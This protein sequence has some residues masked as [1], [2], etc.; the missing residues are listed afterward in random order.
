MKKIKITESQYRRIITEGEGVSVNPEILKNKSVIVLEMGK[1]LEKTFREL[2]ND[3]IVAMDDQE[4][5]DMIS[6]LFPIGDVIDKLMEVYLRYVPRIMESGF[7]KCKVDEGVLSKLLEEFLIDVMYVLDGF[8]QNISRIKALGIKSYIAISGMDLRKGL[9]QNRVDVENQM[10]KIVDD[11]FFKLPYN[12]FNS[13][14]K[15]TI[16]PFKGI[17]CNMT[18]NE[19]GWWGANATLYDIN[20]FPLIHDSIIKKL[21]FQ[22]PP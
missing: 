14:L 18:K 11:M 19:K 4:D 2:I 6:K 10:S 20:F 7:F 17:G 21:S 3:E 15:D 12:Y 5:N 8:I 13:V 1:K 16:K 9:N 22:N